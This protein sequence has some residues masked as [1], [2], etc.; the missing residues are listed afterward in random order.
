M[1]GISFYLHDPLAE[2]RIK[3]ASMQGIRKAFTSLHI[4]EEKGDLASRARRLLATAKANGLEV[5]ADV[6]LKTPRHL[7]VTDLIQLS[8]LGV[9]G[10][11]LDDFFDPTTI[12]KLS[13]HF[14]IALN[15]STISECE[16]RD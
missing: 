11:R 10:I 15:A 14:L 1:I 8:N 3:E 13:K 4:P 7:G 12:I 2:Q 6:S 16:L 5:F 9:A